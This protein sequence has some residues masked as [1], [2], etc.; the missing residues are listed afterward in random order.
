MNVDFAFSI[1]DI[2]T[3]KASVRCAPSGRDFPHLTIIERIAQECHGGIQKKYL[4]RIATADFRAVVLAQH[5]FEFTEIELT[6][7][8]ETTTK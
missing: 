6:A 2:V 3:T 7:I 8:P 4:C 5:P 1:G